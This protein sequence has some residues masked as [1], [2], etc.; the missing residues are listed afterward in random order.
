MSK[1][2][3]NNFSF[4]M[5]GRII[6]SGLQALFYLIF[7]AMLDP[8]SY[9]NLSYII[10]I[11]GT[12]SIISRF[13]LNQTVTIYQAKQESILS[14]N[15]NVLSVITTVTASLILLFFNIYAALLCLSMS[16]FIM[17]IHNF[18]GLK[19]YKK[20][21]FVDILKGIL[22]ITLPIIFYFIFEIPGI[23]LGMSI[24]YLVCSLN[25]LKLLSLRQNN[26]KNF[27]I[28]PKILLHNF[29][30]DLSIHAPKFVD[31]LIVFPIL[32]YSMTG[33]YQLNMQILFGLEML[34]IALHSFLLS[35]ES[36]EKKQTKIIFL[37]I[38]IS[39]LIAVSS[40]FIAPFFIEELF[41]KYSEGIFSLQILLISIIPLT[42][43]SILNAKLQAKNSTLV[44]FSAILR[45]GS[46]LLFLGLL[47]NFY[48]LLGLSLAVLISISLTT[49]FLLIIFF[50]PKN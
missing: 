25:F 21:M 35:E 6:S 45:I 7:A 1:S 9:G 42:I 40:I 8:S 17:N 39:I 37:A 18:M 29:G 15:L 31:K 13:G 47:G 50:K 41:P 16:L 33:I 3:F 20:Y 44:G 22:I 14:N 38:V 28:N 2:N 11:A 23:V 48:D 36:S 27:G 46:L 24:S 10:A 49:I 34:P 30:V 19:K 12:F 4:V 5:F 43:N 32:G 26:F